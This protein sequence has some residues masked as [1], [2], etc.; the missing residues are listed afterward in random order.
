MPETTLLDAFPDLTPVRL[1]DQ[2]G[3]V[4]QLPCSDLL[5][6]A[7]SATRR[8][9][10]RIKRYHVGARYAE[11][12][13]GGQPAVTGQLSFDI[14]SPIRSA[15]ADAE[16]LEVVDKVISEF[17]GMRGTSI[18]DYEF[19]VSHESVL[20]SILASVPDR[21]RP[22]VLK[23]FK[24]MSASTS[25]TQARQHLSTVAGLPKQVLDDLEQC[26][27]AG[28]FEQ[29]RGKIETVFPASRRKLT[30][31]LDETAAIIKLGRACGI[32]RK[33]VF[34]PTLS[35]NAEFFRGGFMFECV[36]R[37]KQR[38]IIAFGGR[39][40][41]LL[42]H[43]KQPAHQIQS[44]RVFGVGMSLAVD[45]LAKVVRRY[46]VGLAERL[47]D[48][49]RVEE[50]SFGFWSPTRC[51]VYV[52]AGVQV[53]LVAR[54]GMTGEFW[55]A[56]IRADLQYDDERGQE[57]VAEECQDQNILFLVI[58]RS[59]RPSVKVRSILRRTEEEV[60]RNEL[61]VHLRQAITEQRRIDASYASAEGSIPSAQAA[62]LSV[63]PSRG[64]DLDVRLVLPPEPIEKKGTK[65]RPVRKHRHVTKSVYYE[66]ASEF[67]QHTKSTLP[68]YGLDLAPS[69]LSQLCLDPAWIWEDEPWRAILSSLQ[70]PERRYVESVRE[71]IRDGSRKDASAATGTGGAAGGG[72]VP[73]GGGS[74]WLF[75]VRDAKGF[76]LQLK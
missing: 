22:H 20:A 44:R 12:A 14:V 30:A 21:S 63:E 75:S 61:I 27:Q 47:M 54:L 53:D 37:T 73:K 36:R 16:L 42:E 60:P 28:D 41:S 76:L 56:G 65:G 66:K 32:T 19:H 25:V 72:V 52:A 13:R 59:N 57:E 3:K 69:L 51:D 29:I 68:L 45:V 1:L 58:P 49:E 74:V 38:E 50:R 18:D 4:V 26:C 64:Q 34:R 2:N 67:L 24:S 9:I 48:K 6:M 5:A 40:D 70:T 11:H 7:R 35:R 39:Y 43:F 10:E 15:A 71:A 17:R 8:G 23:A 62:A 46:E 33:I 55:R 31:A